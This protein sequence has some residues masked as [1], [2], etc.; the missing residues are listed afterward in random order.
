MLARSVA[1]G[2]VKLCQ[3][4]G[5]HGRIF[6]G[7]CYYLSAVSICIYLDVSSTA[8]KSYCHK[9]VRLY[10]HM[11]V[12]CFG[13]RQFECCIC[14]LTSEFS[15]AAWKGTSFLTESFAR[16]SSPEICF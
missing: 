11:K 1:E 14:L 2:L 7:G 13:H 3:W 9:S 6:Y 16:I 5:P 4:G 12:P 10:V 15:L 8:K